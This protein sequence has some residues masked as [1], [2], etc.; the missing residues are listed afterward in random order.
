MTPDEFNR[1]LEV[2]RQ[3]CPCSLVGGFRTVPRNIQVGGASNSFHLYA[4][5]ADLVFDTP[6]ELHLGA[7][8]AMEFFGGVELD[9][10]NNHLHVDGRPMVRPWHVVHKKERDQWGYFDLLIFLTQEKQRATLPLA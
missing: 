2:F 5:A 10:K 7:E 8:K 1:A 9:L 6:R 3:I 4:M